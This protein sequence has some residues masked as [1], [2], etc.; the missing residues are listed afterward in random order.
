MA[1]HSSN[2]DEEPPPPTQSPRHKRR[3]AVRGRGKGRGRERG[4]G[5]GRR[6]RG[7]DV[8]G[9]RRG[10]RSQNACDQFSWSYATAAVN[11]E[12][13]TRRVGPA[14]VLSSLC[15]G[16]LQAIFYSSPDRSHS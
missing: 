12:P 13:F 6:S 11:A 8:S 14:V 4:L 7:G 2:S 15:L 1:Y 9:C 3:R 5:A 16:D 10:G